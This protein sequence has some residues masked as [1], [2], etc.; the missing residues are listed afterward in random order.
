M[1]RTVTNIVKMLVNV[2]Y[3]FANIATKTLIIAAIVTY[4]TYGKS[5]IFTFKFCCSTFPIFYA[6]LNAKLQ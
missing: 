4:V 5:H 1:I 3:Q 6:S 2:K